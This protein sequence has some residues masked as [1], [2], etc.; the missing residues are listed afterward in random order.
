MRNYQE[1]IVLW[2]FLCVFLN[3]VDEGELRPPPQCE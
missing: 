2:A 3:W 1:Q